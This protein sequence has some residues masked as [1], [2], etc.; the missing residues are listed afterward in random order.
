M[1]RC[2]ETVWSGFHSYQCQRKAGHGPNGD[3][4]WQH[5][6]RHL[7]EMDEEQLP[8]IK[9]LYKVYQPY[10]DSKPELVEVDVVEE[11]KKL[12]HIRPDHQKYVGHFSALE[13]LE[14]PHVPRDFPSPATQPGFSSMEKVTFHSKETALQTYQKQQQAKL[15]SLEE[16]THKTNDNLKWAEKQLRGI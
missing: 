10:R 9:V 7:R 15:T 13:K 8:T 11:T 3:Y 2:K 14:D 6:R 16:E 5:S 12:Y 1:E 4:C